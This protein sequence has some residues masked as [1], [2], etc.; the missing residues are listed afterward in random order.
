MQTGTKIITLDNGYHLWTNTQGEGDIHLL[1]LHGGPGGNHEYWED[2]AEQL[3][4][5]GLNVQVTMYDQ[6]GS[7]YS[8]QPDYSDP[9][10]AKKYL[11]YEYFL[12][13]VDEVREKLG[14]D[15]FYLIGQSWGGLLV[16][17]Y[18][19]K[20]GQHLK[21]AIIS[22]MVDEIDD[23]VK[24]VNALREKTLSK[25]AVDFMKDCEAKNDYSNPKYQ[26]YVQV[27][28]ENYIDRKQPSKLYHLKDLG[29]DAVY[30]AFQGDNEFVIT[31]KLKD[32]HFRN[33]LK[34]IKVPTLITF[35]EHESMPIA[36]GKKMAEL[37]PNAKFV[38]TPN[39]GHHHMVDN[40]DVYYKH[41]AD[42]IRDCE[43]N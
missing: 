4:K 27:M 18:A 15:N 30:N 19:V 40:P 25:E 8:D 43:Q 9:E 10:I 11:T 6:L 16:Q 7:L 26:E 33:Q 37:I 42:F 1:A 39:G 20:Y 35:G 34:N 23:Y 24:H 29:G 22:S 12:D 28:N 13:E 31:G 41:L 36:T 17:E 32:W 21:G 3:K 14:L 5:Q 38:T 2:A